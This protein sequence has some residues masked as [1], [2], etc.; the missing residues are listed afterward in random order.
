[1]RIHADRAKVVAQ[2]SKS[3]VSPICNRRALETESRQVP[4]QHSQIANRR[5]GRVQLCATNLPRA[6]TSKPA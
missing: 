3:A 6:E 1:M 5:Y 4:S 2:I